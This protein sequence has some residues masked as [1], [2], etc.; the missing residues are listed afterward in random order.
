MTK[1]FDKVMAGLDDA[2]AYLKGA[3]DGFEVHQ[4][5]VPEPNVVAIRGKTG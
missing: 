5:E 4:I 2:R 3:R 1:A